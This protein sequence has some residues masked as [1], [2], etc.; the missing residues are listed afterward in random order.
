MCRKRKPHTL[1]GELDNMT[2]ILFQ[3]LQC[4]QLFLFV[5]E[6]GL[7]GYKPLRHARRYEF[8]VFL[9]NLYAALLGIELAD[10]VA[11]SRLLQIELLGLVARKIH[12]I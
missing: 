5:F 8:M 7:W 12:H 9:R 2:K 6:D 11:V 10:G 4:T 1:I 3:Y